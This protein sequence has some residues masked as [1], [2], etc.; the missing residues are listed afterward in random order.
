MGVAPEPLAVWHKELEGLLLKSLIL[1]RRA[2]EHI[3]G[4]FVKKSSD[5]ALFGFF[6]SSGLEVV[7]LEEVF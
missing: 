5:I 3:S 6:L 1:R 2:P 4:F 7:Y